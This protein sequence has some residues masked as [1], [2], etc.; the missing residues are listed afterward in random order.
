MSLLAVL[1]FVLLLA[2]PAQTSDWRD[3]V[4]EPFIE[5]RDR[6]VEAYWKAWHVYHSSIRQGTAANGLV[7]RYVGATGSRVRQL[8]AALL[9]A[10]GRYG[11]RAFPTVIS[12]DNFYRKQHADGFVSASIREADGGDGSPP[13]DLDA[14]CPPL[15]SWAEWQHYLVTGDRTRLQFAFPY[16]SR[17]FWWLDTNMR[18]SSGVLAAGSGSLG[19]PRLG[20][21][22]SVGMTCLQALNAHCLADIARALDYRAE[23]ARFQKQAEALTG[24]A[25]ALLWSDEAGFYCDLDAG[26]RQV[27]YER[28]GKH[29]PRAT[30]EGASALLASIAPTDRAKNVAARLTERKSFLQPH[31]F[32]TLP[33]D[34]P[35]F[36]ADAPR[37]GAVS[38]IANYLA[39]RALEEQGFADIAL[40]IAENHLEG[41][42]KTLARTG[43]LWEAY[44]CNAF[45]PAAGAGTDSLGI[46]VC[47]AVATLIESVLGIEV[48][49]PAGEVRW[50]LRQTAKHG[51][52]RLPVGRGTVDLECAARSDRKSPAKLTI[53][54]DLSLTLVVTLGS[55]EVRKSILP[56][57]TRFDVPP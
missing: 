19:P 28:D 31:S 44:A 51:V 53:K 2:P 38:P 25:N 40:L 45:R 43:H 21:E 10:C 11:H 20:A 35:M 57:E 27:S 23:E 6:W 50:D 9:V 56:G 33:A 54:S 4:P 39:I 8:E 46:T 42:S 1:S 47:S 29:V 55:R 48:D 52:R 14:V 41:V 15:L 26:S 37:L 30:L 16:L 13:T 7:S 34:D 12:L 3:L 36:Q 22:G 17:Q 24:V 18:K 32:S 49:A 5:G